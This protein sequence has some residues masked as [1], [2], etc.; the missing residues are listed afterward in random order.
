MA[1][2]CRYDHTI[3]ADTW[4]LVA[5]PQQ[6]RIP[7]LTSTTRWLEGQTHNLGAVPPAA[8]MKEVFV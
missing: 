8:R 5:R 3:T 6:G 1:G 2:R 4:I 7:V